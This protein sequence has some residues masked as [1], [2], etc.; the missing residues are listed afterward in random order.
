MLKMKMIIIG[1]FFKK[2][3][4]DLLHSYSVHLVRRTSVLIDEIQSALCQRLHEA[5][6]T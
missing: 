3:F 4:T 5:C 6:S 1:R 2:L